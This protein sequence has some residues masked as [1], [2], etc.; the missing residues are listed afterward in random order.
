MY[1]EEFETPQSST[2]VCWLLAVDVEHKSSQE[3][4]L[5]QLTSSLHH[6]DTKMLKTICS[7]SV[8]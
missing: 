4:V 8:K 6:A 1:Y 2:W 7:F 5:C 3:C